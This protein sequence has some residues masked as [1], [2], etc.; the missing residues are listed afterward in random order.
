ML[1]S[2]WFIVGIV[3]PDFDNRSPPAF[4][5]TLPAPAGGNKLDAQQYKTRNQIYSLFHSQ[6][7]FKKYNIIIRKLLL[8]NNF[9]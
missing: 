4:G 5:R 3:G 7:P 8:S 1:H 9:R 6:P 2:F